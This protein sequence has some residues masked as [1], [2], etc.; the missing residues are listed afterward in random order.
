MKKSKM[1]PKGLGTKFFEIDE[2]LGGSK[3]SLRL[4]HLVGDY[5]GTVD[6]RRK[7][8]SREVPE[9]YHVLVDN[10]KITIF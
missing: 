8:F 1:S 10:K 4:D 5:E 9:N 6:Q 3:S 2:Y 7:R